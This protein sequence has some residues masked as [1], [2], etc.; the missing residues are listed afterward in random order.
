MVNDYWIVS[1][2]ETL[3]GFRIVEDFRI[4]IRKRMVNDYG[5]VCVF[6]IVILFGM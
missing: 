3:C 2:F 1:V 4:F 6:G 5:I